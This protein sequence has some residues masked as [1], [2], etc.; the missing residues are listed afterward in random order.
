[1]AHRISIPI[2]SPRYV[3]AVNGEWRFFCSICRTVG[4]PAS[5]IEGARATWGVH[6]R[7][8]HEP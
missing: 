7:V 2:L 5:S 4:V 3:T 8:C 6:K 1:M